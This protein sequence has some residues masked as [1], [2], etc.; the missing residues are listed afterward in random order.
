MVESQS[1]GRKM[2]PSSLIDEEPVQK[3][4]LILKLGKCPNK[5]VSLHNG[6][7]ECTRR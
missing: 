7:L 1:P 3:H 6:G 4:V 5:T 2:K